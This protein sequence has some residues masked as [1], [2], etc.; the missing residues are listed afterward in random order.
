MKMDKWVKNTLGKGIDYDGAYGVQCVDLVKH[1]I[2]NVLEIEPQSIGNA[3]EYFNK[4]YTSEYLTSNFKWLDNTADFVPQMGDICVFSS[5]SG[6][7][8]VSIATGD[9]S[10]SYFYSY[11]QNYPSSKHEPMTRI[12]HTYSSLLG[13]LRPKKQ[14]KII[15]PPKIKIGEYKLTNRRGV[16]KNY[17]SKSGLLK[18]A[19]V[20]KGDKKY[21][22]SKVSNA[23]A[24]L[25]KNTPVKITE[26]KHLSSGNLWAKIPSGYICI[27]NCHTDTLYVK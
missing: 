17:G 11:D 9:G 10:K 21:V 6:K 23:D 15:T 13:V 1:Y 22:D 2:K 12:K 3:I 7:G 4:R 24:Y 26:V 16:Y 14:N 8:H 25:K 5:N 27:W 19:F 20:A 18:V